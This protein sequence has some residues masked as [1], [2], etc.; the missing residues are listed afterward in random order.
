MGKIILSVLRKFDPSLS[1][2][3]N[4]EAEIL[5]KM[6]EIRYERAAARDISCGGPDFSECAESGITLFRG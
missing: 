5:G 6:R 1:I 2:G 4:T 3:E